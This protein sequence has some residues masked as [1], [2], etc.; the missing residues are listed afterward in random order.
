MTRPT[1]AV[2]TNLCLLLTKQVFVFTLPRTRRQQQLDEQTKSM[3]KKHAKRCAFVIFPAFL[4]APRGESA[5]KPRLVLL[6]ADISYAHA[7]K[8]KVSTIDNNLG[9]LYQHERPARPH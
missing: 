6:P 2:C 4:S 5:G 8:V 1:Q 9:F 3:H 7:L